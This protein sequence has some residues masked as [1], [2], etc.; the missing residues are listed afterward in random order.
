MKRRIAGLGGLIA[1]IVAAS[2]IVAA[3]AGAGRSANVLPAGCK[4]PAKSKAVRT[5]ASNQKSA[6]IHLVSGYSALDA[7]EGSLVGTWT[8]T[9]PNGGFDAFFASLKYSEATGIMTYRV[10]EVFEGTIKGKGPGRLYI[11]G[12]FVQRFKPGTKLYDFSTFPSEQPGTTGD[13]ARWLG[14][15]CVH[16]ITGGDSGFQGASGVVYFKDITFLYDASY[17]GII[18]L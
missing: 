3:Q 5:P 1:V 15:S 14:G 4:G 13:P 10:P 18:W 7:M 16:R 9:G 8:W 6:S 11:D 17:W 12:F 2:L